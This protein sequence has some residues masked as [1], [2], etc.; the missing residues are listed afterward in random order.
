MAWLNCVPSPWAMGETTMPEEPGWARFP[1]TLVSAPS[2]SGT[3]GT[4]VPLMRTLGVVPV[5]LREGPLLL[6]GVDAD[7]GQLADHPTGR[8]VVRVT[9]GSVVAHLF[10]GADASLGSVH[11]GSPI[12]LR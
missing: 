12:S 8:R 2:N 3:P 11:G 7:G 9:A 6:L 5:D 1:L 10:V 4:L